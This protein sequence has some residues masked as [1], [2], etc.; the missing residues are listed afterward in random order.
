MCLDLLGGLEDWTIAE[1]RAAASWLERP[2]RPGRPLPHPR[3]RDDEVFK[4]PDQAETWRYIDFHVTNYTLGAIEALEPTR[5]PLLDFAKPY[6]DDRTLGYWLSLRDLRDTWQE[7]NN[8][9]NL[10]SF[11]CCCAAMAMASGAAP[12]GGPPLMHRSGSSSSG[13]TGCASLPPGS[14]AWGSSPTRRSSCMPS[15]APCTTP[16]LV[17]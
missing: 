10:A 6:L 15:P 17:P 16:H 11:C 4:K 9:V 3:M 7:G 8:I 14:G 12:T 1:R 5:R 13:M 2:S